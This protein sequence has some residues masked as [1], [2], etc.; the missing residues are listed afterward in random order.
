MAVA[1]CTPGGAGPGVGPTGAVG[2]A[3]GGALAALRDELVA[4]LA[5]VEAR[6]N[7]KAG[8]AGVDEALL[9][10]RLLLTIALSEI[11][12]R[13]ARGDG[14]AIDRA[15]LLDRA[16]RQLAEVEADAR[17]R[18]AT[19]AWA[20]DAAR[21]AAE[22]EEAARRAEASRKLQE[23][24]LEEWTDDL[25]VGG[26]E[27]SL[28]GEGDQPVPE[29]AVVVRDATSSVPPA[30]QRAID[31]QMDRIAPCLPPQEAH[32][33]E[34]RARWFGEHLRGVA[35]VSDPPLVP[36]AAACVV[37]VL[38]GMRLPSSEGAMRVIAF[39]LAVR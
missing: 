22:R 37:E 24:P 30:V 29:G 26:A 13:V 2:A 33:V 28:G 16:R 18:A 39:P 34:V 8:L 32:H 21:A 12:R 38:E 20:E 6:L 17:R 5:D 14:R 4:E 23:R 19:S 35:L 1:A 31:E 27:P 10:R 11:D 15:A 3:Q 9:D 36:A 7:G 25:E